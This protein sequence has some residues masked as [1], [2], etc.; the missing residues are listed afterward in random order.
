[1]RISELAA[2]AGITPRTVRHYHQLGI[3]PE[4]PRQ[5]NGYRDYGYRDLVLLLR[6]RWLTETGLP[7]LAAGTA[8]GVAEDEGDLLTQIEQTLATIENRRAEL[9]RQRILLTDLRDNLAAGRRLS[10][11]PAQLGDAFDSLTAGAPDEATRSAIHAERAALETLALAGALTPQLSSAYA[12]ALADPGTPAL[13]ARFGDLAGR[14]PAHEPVARA[15]ATLA[16][17]LAATPG[18][19][20]VAAAIGVPLPDPAAPAGEDDI[21]LAEIV[22]DPAQRRVVELL[23]TH[24][25]GKCG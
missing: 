22:P 3:L 16:A 11:L 4:P 25:A 21:E 8:S 10:P 2:V 24:L 18:A 6:L 5:A 14:D 13:L 9:D 19:A 23:L 17:D 15:A 1:M 12:A 7:L 20:A